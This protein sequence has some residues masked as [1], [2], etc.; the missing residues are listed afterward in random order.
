[1]APGQILR[2]ASS[3]VVILRDGRLLE[4]RRGDLRGS[5]I[6]DMRTWNTEAAWLA[7]IGE[8]LVVPTIYP[9]IEFLKKIIEKNNIYSYTYRMFIINN[10]KMQKVQRRINGYKKC[11]DLCNEF[12]KCIPEGS[13]T[14]TLTFEQYRKFG[15]AIQETIQETGIVSEYCISCRYKE[16]K[17]NIIKNIK[18][19]EEFL[20]TQTSLLK[21]YQKDLDT[22]GPYGRFD[23]HLKYSTLVAQSTDGNLYSIYYN[24]EHN[25]MGVQT[26]FSI[27]TGRSFKELGI[28]PVAWF[29]SSVYRVFQKLEVPSTT[30]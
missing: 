18:L 6:P 7:E 8:P 5:N 30:E 9:D 14:Y 24:K 22:I 20:Q 25:V 28:I 21:R 10:S 1:M 12:L 16:N 23:T 26:Q 19:F 4:V 11:I 15:S 29:L 17:T 3:S 13:D 27:Q 2:T